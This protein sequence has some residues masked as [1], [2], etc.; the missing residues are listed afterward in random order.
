MLLWA[1]GTVR[2]MI[3]RGQT[4]AG[5]RAAAPLSVSCCSGDMQSL[6][7][8]QCQLWALLVSITLH[9]ILPESNESYVAQHQPSAS[10]RFNSTTPYRSR[11]VPSFLLFKINS[12]M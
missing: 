8:A 9:C 2:R 12:N 11:W 1:L 5:R 6:S 10:A 3:K 4:T 7:P